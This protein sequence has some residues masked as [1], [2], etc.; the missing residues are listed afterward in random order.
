MALTKRWGLISLILFMLP[1][2]GVGLFFIGYSLS[3]AFSGQAELGTVLF[4]GL[5]GLVFGGVGVGIILMA[6]KGNKSSQQVDERKIQHPDKPWLWRKDWASRLIQDSNRSSLSYTWFFAGFWNLISAPLSLTVL[7]REVLQNRNYPALFGLLFPLVG[8]GLLIWAIRATLRWKKFGTSVL[9]LETL[10]GVIGGHLKGILQTRTALLPEEGLSLKL[11]CINRTVSGSGK[12]RSVNE[13]ILWRERQV[14]PKDRIEARV[15]GSS[16][17]FTFEIPYDAKATA[18]KNMDNAILWYVD[19]AASV[20]GVDYGAQFE[21]PLF[22]TSESD[23]DFAPAREAEVPEQMA[24]DLTHTGSHGAITVRPGQRGGTEFYF[25]PARNVR[26][27]LVLTVFT[28][29]WSAVI[30]FMMTQGAPVFFLIVFGLFDLLL[31]YAVLQLWFGVSKVLIESGQVKV[32]SGFLWLGVSRVI[33]C[34]QV[35]DIQISIGMQSGGRSG[36]PY[37]NIELITHAKKKLSLG[38]SIKDKRQADWL[39]T[40]MQDA[41]NQWK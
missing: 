39:A 17:P 32:T 35:E 41:V 5:F 8:A 25:A 3:E 4:S 10:P 26:V 40:T 14:I 7:P 36:T 16:I 34:S 11:T 21:V 29:I 37:Y 31:L 13:K 33:P 38:R 12:N 2:C 9:E 23:P 20:P 19:A 30:W 28:L 1:F 15:Q 18:R 22:R 24:E 6:L 27:A